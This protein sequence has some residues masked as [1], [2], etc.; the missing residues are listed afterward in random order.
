MDFRRFVNK[1]DETMSLK[2]FFR[3]TL[4]VVFV[5]ACLAIPRSASAAGPCGDVYIVKWGDWLSKIANRCS[6]SLSALYEANPG[7]AQ[8]RYIYPGQPLNIPGGQKP[9]FEPGGKPG[10]K[11]GDSHNEWDVPQQGCPNPFCEPYLNPPSSTSKI[12]YYW[13]PSMIVAPNVGGNFYTATVSNGVSFTFQA[14]IRNNGNLPL[15]V[16]ADLTPPAEWDVK[17][18]SNNCPDS[19]NVGGLC[20]FS[21]VFTPH[22]SGYVVV[23][24]Y[25]RGIYTLPS[26]ATNR[27][28]NSPAFFFNVSP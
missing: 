4:I 15:K 17:Q 18:A 13:Y 14:N 24:V 9:D 6:V 8:H 11:P 3:M 2:L 28:T 22:G 7:V 19:L 16:S 26:G 23:R 10:D 5:A 12:L 1:E 25:G 27:I 20:T 21:W